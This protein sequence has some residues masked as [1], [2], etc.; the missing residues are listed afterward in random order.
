VGRFNAVVMLYAAYN[1]VVTIIG[2]AFQSMSF[3]T[4]CLAGC[5]SWFV[6]VF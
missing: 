3:L 6:V 5:V 1:C 4:Q 2:N